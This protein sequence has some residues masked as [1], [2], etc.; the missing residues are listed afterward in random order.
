MKR[1]QESTWTEAVCKKM[2]G[3]RSYANV[4]GGPTYQRN[5]RQLRMLPQSDFHHVA[6]PAAEPLQSVLQTDP[7][8]L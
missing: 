6:K 8:L 7:H 5:R 3:P 4:S 1:P 2:I